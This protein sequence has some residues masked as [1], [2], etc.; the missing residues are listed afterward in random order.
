[1][2]KIKS[3][4]KKTKII[5]GVVLAAIILAIIG[6][7]LPDIEVKNET[8]TEIELTEKE[9]LILELEDVLG[10]YSNRKDDDD[11]KIRKIHDVIITSDLIT[12]QIAA[13]DNL[14]GKSY[15]LF[16]IH[17]DILDVMKE[18]EFDKKIKFEF[19]FSIFDE[20]YNSVESKILTCF[21]P[22]EKFNTNWK[23]VNADSIPDIVS[24]YWKH[25]IIKT[26]N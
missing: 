16:G 7:F 8:T 24:S 12:I 15:I 26:E 14:F 25:P 5:V 20:N 19:Y 6:S 2:K 13:D 3:W 9:K 17:T 1:M 18:I 4:S 21:I 22:T 11:K 23:N 10:E